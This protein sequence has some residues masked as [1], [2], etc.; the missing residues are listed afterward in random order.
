M[1]LKDPWP[2]WSPTQGSTSQLWDQDLCGD[3][4]SD[5]QP[6]K[7]PRRHK[8]PTCSDW[9]Y[10]SAS[11]DHR[12]PRVPKY[13][14]KRYFGVCLGGCF[15]M[16]IAFESVDSGKRLPSPIWGTKQNKRW[17]KGEPTPSVWPL[18]WDIG[19]L[20]PL[21]R[22]LP[23]TLGL[24]TWTELHYRLPRVSSLQTAGVGCLIFTVV[25]LILRDLPP[26]GNPWLIHRSIMCQ[27][28]ICIISFNPHSDTGRLLCV[29]RHKELEP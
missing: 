27:H 11:P 3:Q 9:V 23:W 15:L 5:P 6:P 19:F 22:D 7:P 29:R 20:L 2:A 8:P 14:I 12:V 18:S 28:I 25:G 21:D 4:E 17:R 26:P 10:G 1:L 24:W 13:L 16:T